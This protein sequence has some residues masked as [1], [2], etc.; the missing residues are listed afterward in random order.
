MTGL[1]VSHVRHSVSRLS[2]LIPVGGRCMSKKV[3]FCFVV[4]IVSPL[5]LHSES[6]PQ[7]GGLGYDDGVGS[8]LETLPGCVNAKLH[9]LVKPEGYVSPK[10]VLT[11]L[12]CF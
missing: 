12:I 9:W 10:T 5:K 6:Y 3:S 1:P 8:L 2:S 4:F 7:E 11:V